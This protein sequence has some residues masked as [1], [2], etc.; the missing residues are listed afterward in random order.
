MLLPDET[1]GDV[2]RSIWARCTAL[3]IRR[4][5]VPAVVAGSYWTFA[6]LLSG[7]PQIFPEDLTSHGVFLL[8]ITLPTSL[9]WLW[10]VLPVVVMTVPLPDWVFGPLNFLFFGILSAGGN[11]L[12]IFVVCSSLLE[13]RR[14]YSSS[15]LNLAPVSEKLDP[16]DA[17]C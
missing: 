6:L 16:P 12:M 1:L 15:V 2:W 13:K 9:F 10:I 14:D 4:E 11:A 3:D 8:F 7:V 5:A 17:D